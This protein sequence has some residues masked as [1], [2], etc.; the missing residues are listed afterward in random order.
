[1]LK[2]K[3]IPDEEK[4]AQTL[5]EIKI[6]RDEAFNLNRPT[7]GMFTPSEQSKKIKITD[8]EDI[9]H[10]IEKIIRENTMEII[11]SG[12]EAQIRA[13]RLEIGTIIHKLLEVLVKNESALPDVINAFLEADKDD[14]VTREFLEGVIDNFKE[15]KL[16]ER[17]KQSEAAYT[18]VPF[19]FKVLSGGSYA[20]NTFAHDTYI[21]GIID[22]VFKE[23]GKW[24]IIDYKTYEESEASHDLHKMYEPQ[25]AAYKDVWENLTGEPVSKPEIF[26]VMK[27][28]A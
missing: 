12:N 10:E 3:N 5:S 19:S 13:D 2:T 26:F 18:E 28:Y 8:N 21:N 27:R 16:Y 22:L 24:V 25:L 11:I 7:F 4:V 15:R 17:I 1:M 9:T 14:Y 20:G 6:M 23:N